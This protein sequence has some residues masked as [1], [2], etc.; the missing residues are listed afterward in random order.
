MYSVMKR[1]KLLVWVNGE[2]LQYTFGFRLASWGGGR[3]GCVTVMM[4]RQMEAP[5]F[6]LQWPRSPRGG[7]LAAAIRAGEEGEVVML[8]GTGY[9]ASLLPVV[10][11]VEM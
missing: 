6:A 10:V 9:G 2:R 5:A 8:G 4:A 7:V 3:L 1:T 11:V